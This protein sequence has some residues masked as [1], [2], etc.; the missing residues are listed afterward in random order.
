MA[1]SLRN[2]FLVY[3]F[4]LS[5]TTTNI[6]SKEMNIN[7]NNKINENKEIKYKERI[8]SSFLNTKSD[9]NNNLKIF[10]GSAEPKKE[11]GFVAWIKNNKIAAICIGVAIIVV[12]ALIIIIIFCSLK[13][14]T[15][16]NNLR[17][18]VNKVS[19]KDE[20]ARPTNN[21]IDDDDLL[22]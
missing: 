4:L 12:I 19:F 11:S 15:K 3:V 21:T 22:I 17:E 9:I 5:F 18:Q 14:C 20:D 16:Y 13:V 2:Y 1:N 8:T 6:L 7:N 10:A